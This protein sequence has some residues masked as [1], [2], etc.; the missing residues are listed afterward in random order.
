[1][2]LAIWVGFVEWELAEEMRTFSAWARSWLDAYVLIWLDPDRDWR[3]VDKIMHAFGGF[4]VCLLSLW[5]VT[6]LREL[7]LPAAALVLTMIIGLVYEFGQTDVARSQHLLG[8]PGYG[9]GLVD[10]AYDSIGALLLLAFRFTL[11]ML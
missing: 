11:R 1:M 9:I 4:A 6:V 2:S 8:K 7:P 3:S 10:L 5:L